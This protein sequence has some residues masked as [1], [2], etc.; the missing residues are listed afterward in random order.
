MAG[1][2]S[3]KPFETLRR[4]GRRFYLRHP[5]GVAGTASTALMFAAAG[6][7]WSAAGMLP[8][9]LEAAGAGEN[10]ILAFPASYMVIMS[11]AAYVTLKLTDRARAFMDKRPRL[12]FYR[13]AAPDGAPA[14]VP[15]GRRPRFL[16]GEDAR[17]IMTR[18][19]ESRLERMRRDRENLIRP[20]GKRGGP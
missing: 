1:T 8:P 18:P 13:A 20:G 3:D 10:A 6:A 7:S 14:A 9:M 5:M 15:A 16:E 19:P 4:S 2:V 11:G 12:A 17:R